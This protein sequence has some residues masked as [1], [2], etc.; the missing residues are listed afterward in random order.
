MAEVSKSHLAKETMEPH[1]RIVMHNLYPVQLLPPVFLL[2][3]REN[4]DNV[5]EE[6]ISFNYL[7]NAMFDR[8][9]LS[10]ILNDIEVCV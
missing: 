1:L 6:N 2:F 8:D 9:S 5:V 7:E 3:F 10:Q 4:S